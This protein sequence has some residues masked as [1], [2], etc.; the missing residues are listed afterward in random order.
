MVTPLF[1]Y[2][3]HH[4]L[5]LLHLVESDPCLSFVV[6]FQQGSLCCSDYFVASLDTT[7][8][9]FCWRKRDFLDRR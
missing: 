9:V 2:F 5:D 8:E 6:F 1:N 4:P 7:V 3:I